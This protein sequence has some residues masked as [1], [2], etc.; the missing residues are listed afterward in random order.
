[1]HK[2]TKEGLTSCIVIFIFGAMIAGCILKG[3]ILLIPFLFIALLGL[4]FTGKL[5]F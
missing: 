3:L 4:Y 5:K 1:M 2:I